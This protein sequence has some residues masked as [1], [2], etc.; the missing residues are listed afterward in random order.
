MEQKN[1]FRCYFSDEDLRGVKYLKIN[2]FSILRGVINIP[3]LKQHMA[4]SQKRTGKTFEQLHKWVDEPQK[5]LW[6][7]H[8]VERH[9]TF[10]IPVVR[11]LFGDN[12]I[13]EFLLHI[14]E[15]YEETANKWNRTCKDCGEFT[16]NSYERCIKCYK[17]IKNQ[18]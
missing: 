3:R 10:Y 11:D 14:A 18:D 4:N 7:D 5:Y 16:Y 6:V 12:A 8:R 2:S 15:D 1:R 13:K 9:S 17:K